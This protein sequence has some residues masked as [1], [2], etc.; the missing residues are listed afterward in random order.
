MKPYEIRRGKKLNLNYFHEFGSTCF[1]LND[2]EKMSKFDANSDESI[3]LGY[4]LNNQAYKVYNKRTKVVMEFI[5]VVVDDQG[6]KSTST[7]SG[8]SDV[9][10]KTREK[11]KFS[12]K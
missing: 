6:S 5:N 4:S 9:E 1:S 10:C 12:K 3:F 11:F 8:D 7:R 2:S